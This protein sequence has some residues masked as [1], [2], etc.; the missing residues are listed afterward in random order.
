MTNAININRFKEMHKKG[1]KND[2]NNFYKE[3]SEFNSLTCNGYTNL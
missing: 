3:L 1:K 2:Y